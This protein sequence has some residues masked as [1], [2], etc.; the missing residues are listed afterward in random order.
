MGERS[1]KKEEGLG[2]NFL[3]IEKVC[4][5]TGW[6]R[7]IV[8]YMFNDPAFPY[9]NYGKKKLVEEHAFIKFFSARHDKYEELYWRA[10]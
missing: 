9:C 4:K 5:I 6:S 7:T 8:Q 2:I 10:R 3:D 1:N